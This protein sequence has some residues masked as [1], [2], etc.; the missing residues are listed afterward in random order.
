MIAIL[1]LSLVFLGCGHEDTIDID[2]LL[3]EVIEKNSL[4]GLGLGILRNGSLV[5]Q[6][7]GGYA[8]LDRKIMV[9]QETYFRIASIS[10]SITTYS[11]MTLFD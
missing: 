3:K 8:S 9:S 4:M 2:K 10:K 5:Y 7:S 1:A 6:F 11:L